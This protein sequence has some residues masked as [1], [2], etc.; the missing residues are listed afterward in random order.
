MKEWEQC[1]FCRRKWK[2]QSLEL[3]LCPDCLDALRSRPHDYEG[4]RLEQYLM[5]GQF[6]DEQ[7]ADAV[8]MFYKWLV[9]EE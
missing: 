3:E 8:R 6:E 4:V 5:L 9:E 7:L 1:I 2:A